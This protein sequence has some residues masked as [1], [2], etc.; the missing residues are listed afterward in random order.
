MLFYTIFFFCTG[1]KTSY[2]PL[3]FDQ[4]FTFG[5]VTTINTVVTGFRDGAPIAKTDISLGEAI[6][7]IDG[8]DVSSVLDVREAVATK[9][10]QDVTLS[11]LNLRSTSDQNN[12][13]TVKVKPFMTESG[14]VILGVYL[15]KSALISYDTPVER[16]FAGFLHSYNVL[17]YSVKAFGEVIRTSVKNKDIQP[18]SQSVSGPVGIYSVVGGILDYS[19][20]KV[21]LNLIDFTALMSLS[22]ALVN[23]LPFP[24]LDGGRLIFVV[25]EKIRSGKK[26]NPNIEATVHSIGMFILLGMIILISIKDL[27]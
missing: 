10:G 15:T 23:V 19:G 14:E 27:L 5:H 24:A 9:V 12:K 7:K 18:V 20:N 25:L 26:L 1:F 3:I 8:K 21:V 4:R 17:S 11:L 13:R 22:L 6:L 16:L 2:I